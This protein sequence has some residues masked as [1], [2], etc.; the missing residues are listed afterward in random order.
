[1]HVVKRPGASGFI[2]RLGGCR[3]DIWLDTNSDPRSV[4]DLVELFITTGTSKQLRGINV[5]PS[6]GPSPG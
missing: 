5:R 2:I 1:M 4:A 3:T 6:P